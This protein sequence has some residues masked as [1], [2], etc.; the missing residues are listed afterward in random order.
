MND[1]ARHIALTLFSLDQ[2]KRSTAVQTETKCLSR[3]NLFST[4]SGRRFQGQQECSLLLCK[5]R[6]FSQIFRKKKLSTILSSTIRSQY[7]HQSY[8]LE[9]LFATAFFLYI[10]S[11]AYTESGN[12]FGRLRW[13]VKFFSQHLAIYEFY[14]KLF[15]N[16]PQ[17][18]QQCRLDECCE[19]RK[20]SLIKIFAIE[21]HT[22]YSIR[23]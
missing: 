22:M 2:F 16:I 12:F 18:Q 5:S 8:F 11:I 7:E 23:Q 15:Q 14:Q 3:S 19:K 13:E 1:N 4:R 6:Y 20:K 17:R 9:R 10:Y 21:A